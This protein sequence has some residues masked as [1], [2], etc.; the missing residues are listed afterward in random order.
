MSI[1]RN[2]IKVND[3]YWIQNPMILIDPDRL[4][5]FYPKTSMTL[6]EKINSIIRLG[7]Y[8]GVVLSIVYKNYLFFYIPIV[9]MVGSIIVYYSHPPKVRES[10]HHNLPP[11][12]PNRSYDELVKEV[13][14]SQKE[15]E[16]C[17]APTE[18]NPFMN[19]LLADDRKRP[20][21]CH[22]SDPDIKEKIENNFQ[23]NLFMDVTDIYNK[24]HSQR[25]FYT[26]PSTTVPNDQDTFAKWLYGLPPTCK[27]GNGAMCVAGNAE[28]LNGE[29]YQFH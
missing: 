14:E 10:Y 15:P 7:F 22:Q 2:N 12:Q 11:P 4:T 24:R 19:F 20:E 3:P 13:Q 16:K 1:E 26:M 29:S 17:I 6:G 9:V 25:E 18:D 27:E 21:A 28:R 8:I 23:K 5:Y